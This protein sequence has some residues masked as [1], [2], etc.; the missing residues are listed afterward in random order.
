MIKKTGKMITLCT[1]IIAALGLA[2]CGKTKDK[3]VSDVSNEKY[4]DA[5]EIK[6]NKD[7]AVIDG[8]T[9][10]EFDYTWNCDPGTV[11]EEVECAPAEYYT[12]TKPDTEDAVYVDHE[13]YYYPLLDESGFKKIRYDGE[14]EW[15]YYYTD[16]TNNSYIFATLP[17]LGKNMPAHMMHSA[18]EASE[19]KVLH[20][21]K[22]GKYVLSGEWDGQIYVDCGEDSF[23]NEEA[24]VTLIL[25]GANIKCSVAP[26]IVFKN[27]YESDN[28]WE[29]NERTDASIDTTN[30]GASIIIA[31]DSENY[32]S[33]ENVFRML[34]TKYKDDTSEE[35]IKLQK[36]MRKTDGA[37]YSYMTMNIDGE[38]KGNGSL[39]V[40]SSFEGIDSELHLN[41]KGGNI[42]INSQD[43]GMNVNEDHTSVIAFTGGYV[44]INAA[45]GAEGD[46]VD[47]N[48]Y[49]LIDGGSVSVNGIR[50]PDSALDSEDGIYYQSGK[51][52]ID[53]EEQ[54]YEKNS[55]FNETRTQV[56]GDNKFDNKD[57]N[58]DSVPKKP[59]GQGGPGEGEPM[60][61]DRV[62]GDGNGAGF[63]M[64]SPE[65]FDIKEFK[66]QVAALGDD[67]TLE[68][69]LALIGRR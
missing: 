7:S 24:K 26:G 25:N 46:G 5:V 3:K 42:T 15:A 13:L 37:L 12:G 10:K 23:D 59:D 51:I 44:T 52:I 22:P 57:N 63:G 18:Q 62:P 2:A 36:K 69:V 49:I 53:G 45:L 16:G 55:V 56:D 50:V 35:E 31:D 17:N 32:V 68:D 30:A 20:I 48:G 65:D 66:K 27:V 40:E 41:V 33:G 14:E 34:K 58:F 1:C 54:N 11:H 8:A 19:N 28:T 29:E 64:I 61:N 21:T 47:S 4:Q 6:L 67:A 60:Q 38:E 39:N 43:D 9:A